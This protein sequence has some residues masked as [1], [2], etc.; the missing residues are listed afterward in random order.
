MFGLRGSCQAEIAPSF[1]D[2]PAAVHSPGQVSTLAPAQ[3]LWL[4]PNTHVT[5]GRGRQS[6]GEGL[7]LSLSPSHPC[8]W[9]PVCSSSPHFP[10]VFPSDCLP[11]VPQI[12][13]QSERLR[14]PEPASTGAEVKPHNKPTIISETASCF[15]AAPS[16]IPPR[17]TVFHDA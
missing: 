9:A 7:R 14:P 11:R 5:N 1:A 16:Q 2:C 8:L 3:G 13:H 12:H 6:P 15:S 10:P 4:L 17:D